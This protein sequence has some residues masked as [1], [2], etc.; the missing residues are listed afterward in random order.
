V[1]TERPLILVTGARGLLGSAL[2]RAGPA[3]VVGLGHAE[4][5]LTD[6]AGVAQ[7]LDRL[8][9]QAVI[10]A[11]AQAGVDRAE[12][13]VEQTQAVNHHA[14]A[15]LA[16]ACRQRGIRLLHIGTDYSLRGPDEPGRYLEEDQPPDPQGV[17][18]TSKSAGEQAALAEGAVVV[19]V[20]WVYH[21]GHPGFFT[22][23]LQALAQGAPLR[24]VTDQV[25]APTPA[26]L[27]A[28]ALLHAA[29]GGPTGLFHLACQGETTPWGWIQAAAAH[30]GLP[31]RAQPILRASLG[32]APRPARSVLDSRRFATTFG[33]QLPDWR[34]ALVQVLD[35][36][37]WRPA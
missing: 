6:A 4:L 26:A 8:R 19:R 32:G 9:P 28:P 37:R 22:R 13:A 35:Q 2:V 33:L 30:L 11:A 3:S 18:A 23:S 31:W 10:N 17:Y 5:D 12:Q 21:P 34:Q 1:G 36:T 29:L 14:V 27:L 7:A 25:G 15:A 16:R 20:Q 24:L